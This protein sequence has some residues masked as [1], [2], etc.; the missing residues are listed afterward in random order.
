MATAGRAELIQS[1]ESGTKDSGSIT[2][3]QGPEVVSASTAFHKEAAGWEVKRQ[4]QQLS[5]V[6]DPSTW[7]LANQTIVLGPR[8]WDFKVSCLRWTLAARTE[9]FRGKWPYRMYDVF[10][11]LIS[12]YLWHWIR[13]KFG[14][15]LPCSCFALLSNMWNY[16]LIQIAN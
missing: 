11:L 12:Y 10:M 5:Q 7:R 1:K 2:W 3:V 14:S 15:H 13:W 9:C 4:E 16:T 6:Q 8:V